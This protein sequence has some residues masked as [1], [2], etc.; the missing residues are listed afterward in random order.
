M[1]RGVEFETPLVFL[2][3]E[4]ATW[5]EFEG[6]GYGACV[7]DQDGKLVVLFKSDWALGVAERDHPKVTFLPTAPMRMA[8]A[9]AG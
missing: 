3:P 5:D 8:G 4:G 6:K 9:K 1:P 7:H 2:F